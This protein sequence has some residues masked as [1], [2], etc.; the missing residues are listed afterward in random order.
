MAHSFPDTLFYFLPADIVSQTLNFGIPA[1]FDIQ[2]RGRDQSGNRLI[3][4]RLCDELKRVTGVVDVRIQQPADLP[5][6]SVEVDREK[7]ALMG[8]SERDVANALLLSLSGSGQVQPIFWLNPMIGV[9]RNQR[10][11]V[12]T[13]TAKPRRLLM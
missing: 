11:C 3:A 6:L 4:A 5:R 12:T 7:A 13:T 10:S 2:I 1:P 8:L 9:Q